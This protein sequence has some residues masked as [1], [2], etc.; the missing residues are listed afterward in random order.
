MCTLELVFVG[1][2]LQTF[3]IK[4]V[5]IIK[6]SKTFDLLKHVESVLQEKNIDLPSTKTLK[7]TVNI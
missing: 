5:I 6:K 2:P 7:R 1:V 4:I 3:K